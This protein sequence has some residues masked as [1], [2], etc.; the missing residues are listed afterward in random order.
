ML[1]K[2]FQMP[3]GVPLFFEYLHKQ[4]F[5]AQLLY[6]YVQN[7]WLEKVAG[8]VY[9]TKGKDLAPLMIIKAIQE[10][11][12]WPFYIGAQSA[13]QLQG[14]VQTLTFRNTYLV[15]VPSRCRVSLWLKNLGSFRF[16]KA[17]L[18]NGGLS[19]LVAF[20]ES[21][22]KISVP[23]RALLEMAALVPKDAEYSEIIANMELTPNLRARL[24][25]SLL[26]ECS[27]VKAK[28]IFLHVAETQNHRWVSKLDLKRVDLGSGPRQIVKNGVYN[29]KFQIYLPK[30]K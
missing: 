15:F 12:G 9:K 27:S 14:K 25:Q 28:R 20:E 2:L 6:K 18:F 19:G 17:N 24:V 3:E 4:G 10:Q 11:L 5:S 21:G 23:E 7:G 13:L 8:G 30:D 29:K 22:P 1:K 16:I 26:E